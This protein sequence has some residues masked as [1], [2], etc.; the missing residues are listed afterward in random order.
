MSNIYQDSHRAL[1][2]QFDTRRLADTIEGGFISA[3]LSEQDEAFIGSRDMFWLSTVDADGSPTVSYKGG[4]PGFVKVVDNTTI[5]FPSYN[6]NGMCY[7]W[8]L[9]NQSGYGFKVLRQSQ[10]TT[11]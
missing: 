10:I 8:T 1:Q 5:A 2:D 3:E 7:L 11:H 6:G 9:K 4:D